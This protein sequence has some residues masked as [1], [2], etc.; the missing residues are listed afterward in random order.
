MK[1]PKKILCIVGTR[2]EVIKMAPVILALK[3]KSWANI[4]ILVTAQHRDLLDPMMK[5]FDLTADIDLNIMT[6]NQTLPELTSRLV[7]ELDRLYTLEKPDLVIAQG[8]TTTTFTAALVSF[9]H[10]IPFAHVEAGLRT[11]DL[12]YPFPEEANRLLAGHLSTLHFAPTETAKKALLKENIAESKISVTG[13]TVIDSLHMMIKKNPT[14]EITLDKNKKLILVTAHRREN[15]GEP[16]LNICHA[17]KKIADSV[18]GIQIVDPVH[19]NPNV[20]DI[21]YRE[22]GNHP[23]IILT[24]PLDYL[25]FLALMN[26]CY[27]VLTDSGGIQ[28]EAP[29]LAKPVLVLR[30][31]TE[32]PE[33]VEAGV[34]KLVGTNPEVIIAETKK[35][36][37]DKNYYKNMAKG[38]SPYGDGHA[39]SRIVSILYDYLRVN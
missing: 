29:A 21:A 14:H 2:P 19:P 17:L 5:L 12:Y 18:D 38:V 16:F 25:P 7:T 22:L 9:Y 31:E 3:K 1:P 30:D 8:D 35:L 27:C 23:A 10:K 26:E 11:H 36:L 37:T 34:V 13:N 24:K 20:H 39:A 15:F 4:R 33:A 32:R 28:E 6:P